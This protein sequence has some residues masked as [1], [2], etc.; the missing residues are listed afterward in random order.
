MR[1]YSYKDR[2]QKLLTPEIVSLL[3]QIHEFKGEQ[4][5]FIEAN[6]DSLTELMYIAKIQ[7]TEGS[8]A[9]EGIY[10]SDERL[11]KLVEDKTMPKTRNEKEIAGYRDVLNTIHENFNHIPLKPSIILQLHRDLYKFSG[12]SIGGNFK[13][14]DNVIAEEDSNGE[15][16]IRFKPVPAWETAASMDA[17]CDSYE[18]AINDQSIDN[19]LIVPMLILDFLCVHPFN[20][21]NGRMSRLLTLLLF[22]RS[23]YIVGKYISIEKIIAD[24]KQTYYDA[25]YNSSLNWHE[26]ENDYSYFVEYILGIIIAAYRDF[27]TRVITLTNRNMSKPE[28][29]AEVIRI[30]IGK[31]TKA[32]IMKKCPNISDTTIQRSLNELLKKDKIIKHGGG[33]YTSYTWNREGE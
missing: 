5:L 10:T 28:R 15:K 19:L 18:E 9:I 32:E 14:S 24:T 21:G 22:Y 2:W 20:D 4:N 13:N 1:N 17:L 12:Q 31:I 25:L 26:E 30:N 29:V 3:T 33:R 27:S 23:G 11:K 7:S 16:Y 6:A 8:N